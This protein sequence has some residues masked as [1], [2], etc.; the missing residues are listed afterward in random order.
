M[1][2]AMQ[3][4]DAPGRVWVL[5]GDSE[6]AEGSIWEAMEAIA[7]HGVDRVTC[8]LDLNRLGQR[9]PTMHGWNGEVFVRRAEAFGWAATAGSRTSV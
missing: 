4:D 9:G 1:G 7:Y 3:L 5:V 2:L 8:V 6:M